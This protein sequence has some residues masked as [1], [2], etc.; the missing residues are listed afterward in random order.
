MTERYAAPLMDPEIRF[1]MDNVQDG[2]KDGSV[3][4]WQAH[5]TQEDEIVW[6]IGRKI[7]ETS[8][9][10]LAM[11]VKSS[12]AVR[13]YAPAKAEGGWDYSQIRDKERIIRP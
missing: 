2:I 7:N 4:L 10:P 1:I 5:D 11:L 13:R 12:E 8:V 9:M 6:V 3:L